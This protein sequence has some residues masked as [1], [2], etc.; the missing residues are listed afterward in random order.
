MKKHPYTAR[1][2]ERLRIFAEL[3]A[4]DGQ[5]T[6]AAL[7]AETGLS[8]ATIDSWLHLYVDHGKVARVAAGDGYPARG[9]YTLPGAP[10]AVTRREKRPRGLPEAHS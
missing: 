9:R 6:G 10:N 5:V 7:S 1:H 2:E 4:R 8:R 3:V